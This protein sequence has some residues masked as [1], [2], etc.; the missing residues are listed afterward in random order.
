[1]NGMRMATA[2]PLS[3]SALSLLLVYCTQQAS[4]TSTGTGARGQTTA[5]CDNACGG[6]PTT[7]ASGSGGSPSSPP[8]MGEPLEDAGVDAGPAPTVACVA[9]AGMDAC[10][11]P[12]SYCA[13]S[14]WLVFYASA[15]C[16]SG[17][18]Q[19]ERRALACTCKNGGCM[20]NITL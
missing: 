1:M 5:S 3:L 4:Q 18:C 9:D 12:P 19:Y 15:E 14:S 8:P 20:P 10:T 17:F 11:L 6:A 13:D 16:V 2:A 7:F